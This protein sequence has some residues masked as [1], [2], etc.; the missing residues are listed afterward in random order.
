MKKR[1]VL[2]SIIGVMLC[3]C[4]CTKKDTPKSNNVKESDASDSIET[5]TDSANT[6]SDTTD[7]SSDT[8][9]VDSDSTDAS[10][11]TAIADSDS[12]DSS[13]D[14]AIVNS[15]TDAS[16]DSENIGPTL[17]YLGH[18]STKITT[19]K[20]TIIYIDPYYYKG[21]Y[22]SPADIILITHDHSDHNNDSL[23]TKSDDSQLIT[24][25]TALVD[26]VYQTFTIDDVT[27]EAVPAGGNNNHPIGYGVGYI[28]T[29]DDI[30]L[31]QAGDTSYIT[32]M[33]ALADRNLDYALFPIDGQYNM[34]A[35]EATKV[36]GIVGAKNSI[37]I[38][39]FDS[40]GSHK[41]D[42]FTPENALKLDYGETIKLSSR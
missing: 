5:G 26:N 28:L 42:D 31:Y 34:D 39:E 32:E 17:T 16:S 6:S 25:K 41:A 20:G 12:T 3:L 27:I 14:S 30:T 35:I 13:S 38:H 21:D 29:F 2:I 10:S 22:S 33:D 19:S 4:S 36:A 40:N 18:A 1:L 7:A 11:D 24:A 9:N 37:P 15:D 23:C 8:A